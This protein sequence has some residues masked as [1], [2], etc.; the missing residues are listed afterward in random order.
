MV[1]VGGRTAFN[2]K[3]C[4]A[5]VGENFVKLRL[6]LTLLPLLLLLLL[7]LLVSL[8][9]QSP[10]ISWCRLPDVGG[11][12]VAVATIAHDTSALAVLLLVGVVTVT[13]A[14]VDGIMLP[15]WSFLKGNLAICRCGSTIN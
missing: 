8:T 9:L 13:A 5:I 2:F 10:M 15:K 4:V 6:I 14:I 11:S 7:F 3:V 12:V 1:A